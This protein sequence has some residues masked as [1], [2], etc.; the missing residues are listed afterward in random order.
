VVLLQ[1]SSDASAL[2]PAITGL[3]HVGRH[4]GHLLAS[5]FPIVSSKPLRSPIAPAWHTSAALFEIETPR[6]V[7]HVFCVHLETPRDGLEA[8]RYGAWRGADEMNVTTER[9]RIESEW[10]SRLVGEVKGPVLV[11]GDFNTPVESRIYR[12]YWSELTNA[13]SEAGFGFGFTRF[14]RWLN[15]RIDHVLVDE[16]WRVRDAWVGPDVGSDHLPVLADLEL[17]GQP[18]A[19]PQRG[20]PSRS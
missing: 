10:A 13:F 14:A 7:I 19:E 16:H 8:V 1:E 5:R 12:S 4:G 18:A 6:G 2:A 3:K 17:K 11:A 20:V 15:V 9:R